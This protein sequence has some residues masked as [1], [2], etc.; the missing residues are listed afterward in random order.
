MRLALAVGL[1]GLVVAAAD[2]ARAVD[3]AQLQQLIDLK[4]GLYRGIIGSRAQ[5]VAAGTAQ[6]ILHVRTGENL[7][8]L[9]LHFRV[10]A[11]RLDALAAAI[12]LPPG[13]SLAKVPVV[14]GESPQHYLTVALTEVG[15][16]RTGIRAE[17]TT[18]VRTVDDPAPRTLMLDA[19]AS[20]ASLD[21]V[22]L[23]TRPA[24]RLE[25]TVEGGA[26]SARVVA[27]GASFSAAFPLPRQAQTRRVARAW[28][29]AGDLI[30]WKNGVV[31]RVYYSGLVA[32]RRLTRIEPS[33][34]AIEDRTAWAAFVH[35]TPRWVL[36]LRERL[37]YAILPWANVTDAA[38]DLAPGVRDALVDTKATAFSTVE[39]RRAEEIGKGRAEPLAEFLLEPDPPSIFI[40]FAIDPGKRQALADAIPLPDGVELARMTT[41]R[42]SRRR[43]ILVLNVYEAKGLAPGLRAEW[44]VFVTTGDDPTPS[45]MVIEAQSSGGSLDPV[46]LFTPPADRFTYTATDGVLDV[47]LAAEGHSFHASIP[48]AGAPRRAH[49]TL[50][51]SEANNRIYWS[52]GVYD[53]IYYN[54]LQ[55]DTAMIDVPRKRVTID[56]GS[57]WAPFVEPIGVLAFQN[58]LEFIASPWFNLD[59]LRRDVAR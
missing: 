16:D 26:T 10:R 5:G 25:Y 24:E 8:T 23:E 32:N 43:H 33:S 12:P 54:G 3:P 46:H 50:E 9:W 30:Y 53:R 51:W 27:A 41:V 20:T 36:L 4:A 52:N 42:G 40:V 28:N 17:W 18:Y 11:D 13:L 47:D 34:V 15:G 19:Q 58:R 7:P 31:D 14:R 44:S 35:P 21:P 39:S 38:L 1:A 57:R 45:Y 55:F 56:D 49:P 48:L 59:E 22:R 2:A 6:P 29:A 37:D